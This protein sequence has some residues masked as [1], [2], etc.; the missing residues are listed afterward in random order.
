[1]A[2]PCL[3]VCRRALPGLRWREQH[4]VEAKTLLATIRC[5]DRVMAI[6]IAH[7]HDLDERVERLAVRLGLRGRGRKTAVI[8]RALDALENEAGRGQ[9]DRAAVRASLA[10]YAKAGPRL[11]ERLRHLGPGAGR[12]LSEALQ[13]DLYDERGLPR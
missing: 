9:A 6:N 13:D 10:R 2:A 7:R 3:S 11:R 8:E 5:Y 1:M 4:V 12:P